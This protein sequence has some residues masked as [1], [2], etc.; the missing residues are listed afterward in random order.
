MIS[1]QSAVFPGIENPLGF[2]QHGGTHPWFAIRVRSNYERTT[3]IHLRERGYQEFSPSHKVERRWSDRKKTVEQF[4]FPGYVF[5]RLDPYDRLPI[6]TI[7]GVIGL[8]GL[9]KIPSPIP[10]HE[11]ENVRTMVQSGL[12]VLPWPCLEV[13]QRVLIEH[14]PLAGV[15]GILQEVKSKWR[16]VVSIDLL[17]R[18]VSTEVDRDWVRPVRHLPRNGTAFQR[19]QAV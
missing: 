13:G 3:T 18:A 6:L 16:L 11:I 5:S 8:V 9:G 14:G 7:P 12:L 15:E 4:L 2:D 17:R 10:D 1:S 19:A